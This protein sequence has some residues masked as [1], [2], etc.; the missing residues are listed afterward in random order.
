MNVLS[1]VSLKIAIYE[2][3][4]EPQTLVYEKLIKLIT[5]STVLLSEIENTT[6]TSVCWLEAIAISR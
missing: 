4:N 3:G 1:R 2:A 5:A 6:P